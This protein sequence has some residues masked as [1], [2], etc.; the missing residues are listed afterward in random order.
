MKPSSAQAPGKATRSHPPPAKARVL[1][2]DDHPIFRQ[3][4]MALLEPE[5]DLTVCAEAANARDALEAAGATRPQ[6]ALVDLS[7]DGSHGLDLLREFKAL[8]PQLRVIILS[9][10]DEFLYAESALRAGAWGYVTKQEPPHALL[11]AIRKVLRGD[12]AFGGG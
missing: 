11:E 12:L 6:L 10:Y 4:L 8:Y 3:G 7:L 2:V 1:L 5:P 9:M